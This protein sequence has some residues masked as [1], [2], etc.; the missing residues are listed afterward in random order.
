MFS[1]RFDFLMRD[2]PTLVCDEIALRVWEVIAGRRQRGRHARWKLSAVSFY[3]IVD[4]RRFLHA[5]NH[6]R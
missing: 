1:A 6:R 2:C 3:L 5:M 4:V